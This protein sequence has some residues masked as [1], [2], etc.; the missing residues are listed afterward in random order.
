MRQTEKAR[1][2][3]ARKGEEE[4]RAGMGSSPVLLLVPHPPVLT[5]FDCHFWGLLDNLKMEFKFEDQHSIWI[6]TAFARNG[7]AAQVRR[8]FILT[9]K[10]SRAE[11][12]L[13]SENKIKRVWERFQNKG[14]VHPQKAGP[15]VKPSN[16]ERQDRVQEFFRQNPTLSTRDAA[17]E[18][19]I[20]KSSVWKT[21]KEL[22]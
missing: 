20:P 15:K 17:I 9:F 22:K 8:E 18:L 12:R 2:V 11:A 14:S 6:A 1:K 5:L 3:R 13:I 4:R 21:L 19:D 10:L 7:S 16:T